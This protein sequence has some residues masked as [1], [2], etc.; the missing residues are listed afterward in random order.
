[1]LTRLSFPCLFV[2]HSRTRCGNL[3]FFLQQ[4]LLAASIT[5]L[6][7]YGLTP[8]LHRS[9]SPLLACGADN[10]EAQV[11]AGDIGVA[12]ELVA[13]L[14]VVGVAAPAAAVVAYVA[15]VGVEIPEILVQI[16][17]PFPHVSAHVIQAVTVRLF[18]HNWMCLFF[19]IFIIPAHFI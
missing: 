14:A 12:P 5:C 2:C 19:A 11:V 4:R 18:L 15:V 9:S 8:A 16:S 17:A 13:H 7:R 10:A 6:F 1:M 3:S